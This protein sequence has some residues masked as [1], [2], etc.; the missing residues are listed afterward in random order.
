M[1]N[2]FEV[3]E[4]IKGYEGLYQI[5]TLGRVKSLRRVVNL[6]KRDGL[7][8]IS[9]KILKP[10]RDR[11]G[12]FYVALC[13]EGTQKTFKIHRLVAMTFIPNPDNLPHVLH[14]EEDLE[15]RDQVDNLW[16]GSDRHNTDDKVSK[17]RQYKKLTDEEVRQIK[18]LRETRR[19]TYRKLA[20]MYNV[21]AQTILNNVSR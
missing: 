5:S 6:V 15:L 8:T 21:S 16:W 12:Y 1:V 19:Y 18:D 3:W 11:D 20:E 14:K 17:G 4:D 7:R 13:K 2:T 9:E 10:S